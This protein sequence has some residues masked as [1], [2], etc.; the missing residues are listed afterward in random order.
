MRHLTDDDSSSS[1]FAGSNQ[2][3][4]FLATLR[5]E[6]S[7][8][9]KP[10]R[11]FD[12]ITQYIATLEEKATWQD[13]YKEFYAFIQLNPAYE[14]HDYQAILERHGLKWSEA[15]MKAADVA[16][17]D[18]QTVL[19]LILGAHRA[20]RFAPGV[21]EMF[22]SEGYVAKWLMRLKQLDDERRHPPA[23]PILKQVRLSLQP[24]GHGNTSELVLTE[25]QLAIK[26]RS[27]TGA[28]AMHN[29]EF[30][31]VSKF[32]E[33]A[34]DVM[35]ECLEAGGWQD[36][37]HLSEATTAFYLYEMEA[38]YECGKTTRHQ[39]VFDRAHIPEKPFTLFVEVLRL[40]I[41]SF[42]FGD[43]VGLSGFRFALKKG[44]VKYCGVLLAD[45]G[46]LYYYR[47]TDLRIDVGDVVIVPVGQNNFEREGV[48]ETV[49]FCRWDDT[50]YPLEKTKEII[51][52]VSEAVGASPGVHLLA[53]TDVSC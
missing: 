9:G 30:D 23:R 21:L 18:E 29:Y 20:E 25:E 44:E 53:A 11:K 6:R 35:T 32:G 38:E 39:G 2:A 13:F 19:A 41:Q 40:I 36:L 12:V 27:L 42:G 37:Q 46:K 51:R 43:V 8:R 50:P 16:A 49:E 31:S 34:L 33:V 26:S 5:D 7:S 15:A 17:L 1:A 14:L 24:L 4:E 28:C 22:I 52:R 48:V 3:R 47:T 45:G 10:S